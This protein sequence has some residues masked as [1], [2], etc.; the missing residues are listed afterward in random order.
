MSFKWSKVFDNRRARKFFIAALALLV[1]WPLVAWVAAKRLI[2]SAE[3]SRA[4]ALV[5]LAGSSAY[6]ERTRLAASLFREGRA[7]KII[8]TDD[9]LLSGWSNELQRN[10]LFVE[11]EAES[12]VGAGVPRA[13]IEQLPQKVSGTHDEALAALDYAESHGLHSLLIVT[14]SYHSRRALWTFRTVFAGS[15]VSVGL[16]SVAPGD[17]MPRPAVWW[18]RPRG[19]SAVAGE[20]LKFVYYWLRYR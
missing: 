19:W 15:G 14:S 17:Q 6:N 2:V 3:L 10:P 1:G 7:P 4:D 5:V 12:L 18:L 11:R 9:G 13:E 8:L 16:A 20:Y